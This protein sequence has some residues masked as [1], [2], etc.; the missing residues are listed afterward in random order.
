M[1]LNDS[2]F[3]QR[4]LNVSV[5]G[6]LALGILLGR[7]EVVLETRRPGPVVFYIKVSHPSLPRIILAASKIGEGGEEVE[8][9][10]RDDSDVARAVVRGSVGAQ[11]GNR[12]GD[13]WVARFHL[14]PPCKRGGGGPGGNS[15]PLQILQP[16]KQITP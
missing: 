7:G 11:P 12:T 15:P 13:C 5:I 1:I 16:S 4:I 3:P 10:I 6:F 9:A 14:P 8:V 2:I